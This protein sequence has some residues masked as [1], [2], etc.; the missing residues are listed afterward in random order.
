MKWYF[1]MFMLCIVMMSCAQRNLSPRNGQF[2]A[3]ECEH[4]CVPELPRIPVG[5]SLRGRTYPWYYQGYPY[6]GVYNYGSYRGI[7]YSI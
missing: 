2:K 1:V 4:S 6:F 3:L 7:S 5:R